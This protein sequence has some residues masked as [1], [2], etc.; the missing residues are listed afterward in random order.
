MQNKVL[1]Q[2]ENQGWKRL[3]TQLDIDLPLEKKKDRKVLWLFLLAG[4]GL[5]GIVWISLN[6]PTQPPGQEE[7]KLEIEPTQPKP[8]I[9][10]PTARVTLSEDQT[11]IALTP[12]GPKSDKTQ[13]K[14]SGFADITRSNDKKTNNPTSV[15]SGVQNIKSKSPI[16]AKADRQDNPAMDDLSHLPKS[17]NVAAPHHVPVD[18]NKPATQPLNH[19][20]SLEKENRN[21]QPNP[22]PV[23]TLED[24]I[25]A[26]TGKNQSFIT[27]TDVEVES[28]LSG[29]EAEI[30]GAPIVVPPVP[31]KSRRHNISL[32]MDYSSDQF[33]SSI[34]MAGKNWPVSGKF[35]FAG[36]TGLGFQF[37]KSNFK[38]GGTNTQLA[39]NPGKNNND[40]NNSSVFQAV[41]ADKILLD[42]SRLISG[43]RGDT[44]VLSASDGISFNSRNQWMAV[45][46]AGI[47]FNLNSFWSLESGLLFKSYLTS[48]RELL[49]VNYAL[50][51]NNGFNSNASSIYQLKAST[52]Q[53]QWSWYINSGFQLARQWGLNLQFNTL[54]I[55]IRTRKLNTLDALNNVG[56]ASTSA[57]ILFL[58]VKQDAS[59]LRLSFQYT[60]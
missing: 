19:E 59:A 48:S 40:V 20:K 8:E 53:S 18:E 36:K 9:Q 60:F 44:L 25:P 15:I 55:I 1:K 42:Q 54:P 30:L 57:K 7:K 45:V 31:L 56:S 46:Q 24:A 2:R 10:H 51:A 21:D 35:Y 43:F 34:L 47:G 28:T 16:I 38:T 32:G 50:G 27:N 12:P 11:S 37:N 5:S 41:N 52:L 49:Q 4:L 22:A 33:F 3:R 39:G 14:S 26:E 17:N 23:P 6:N 29:Q 58:P 13:I